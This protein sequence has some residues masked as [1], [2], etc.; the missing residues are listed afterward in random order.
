[1]GIFNGKLNR[2]IGNKKQKKVAEM[3]A[4]MLLDW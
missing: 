1:M 3:L 2:L 4:E